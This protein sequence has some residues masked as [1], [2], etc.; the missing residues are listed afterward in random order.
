MMKFILLHQSI[1]DGKKWKVDIEQ[2]SGNLTLLRNHKLEARY[3]PAT[4]DKGDQAV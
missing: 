2:Q 1:E 4:I 3:V